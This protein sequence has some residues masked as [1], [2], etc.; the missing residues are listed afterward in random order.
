MSKNKD[1]NLEDTQQLRK[2]EIEDALEEDTSGSFLDRFSDS[3]SKPMIIGIVILIVFLF[4]LFIVLGMKS[5]NNTVEVEQNDSSSTD[6]SSDT[7]LDYFYVQQA[8]TAINSTLTDKYGA[9]G[10]TKPTTEQYKI[11]GQQSSP[12]IEFT[13]TVTENGVTKNVPCKFNLSYN[14]EDQTYKVVDYTIDDSKAEVSNFKPNT[15]EE[16]AK[17]QA[18]ASTGT[19]VSSYD[20]SVSNSVT[21]TITSKGSGTVRAVAVAS[22]GNETEIASVTDGT[23]TKTADLEAGDYELALYADEGTGYSWSYT[24]Q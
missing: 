5:C 13:L 11:S 21:V 2:D 8:A 14:E 23:E 19:K 9:S 12:T 24:I 7:K 18:I 15:S 4:I 10:F 16:E 3:V 6:K 20:I 22:D 1:Q 17:K